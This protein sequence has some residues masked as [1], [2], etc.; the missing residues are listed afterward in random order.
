VRSIAVVLFLAG[1]AVAAADDAAKI[2]RLAAEP[3]DAAST[4][5]AAFLSS[6][7]AEVR[8][9]A[10]EALGG[11]TDKAAIKA[12]RGALRSFAK[13]ADLLPTVVVAVGASRDTGSAKAVADLAKKAVGSDLR[14]AR[15]CIDSLGQ[16]P[17]NAA[18]ECL[19]N[20]LAPAIDKRGASHPEL[21]EELHQSL[22]EVT[23][24]PFR[25]P[26]TF[27]AWWR[28]AKGRFEGGGHDIPPEG[29]RYRHDGWRFAI[30]RPDA[31]RFAFRKVQGAVVRIV[32]AGPKEEAGFAW[33]DVMAQSAAEG[34]PKTAADDAKA[35]RKWMEE[36]LAKPRDT[37]FGFRA[38]LGRAAAVGNEATGI[39]KE[40]HVVRW[41]TFS[42][43]K[44]GL[45]YTVSAH[46]ESGAEEA[47][48][49]EVDGILASFRLLDR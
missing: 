9:A 10:V 29:D 38:K 34:G 40:G 43:E 39:L 37:R 33:I 24:L 42:V 21:A 36:G 5:I 26:A 49:G 20:L 6:R 8:R 7:D 1:V 4:S 28:H 23:G 45:V 35:R 47:V 44:N 32:W 31:K 19:V 15:A 13:D 14:L 11:R 2:R 17:A 18:V 41:R 3:G 25:K 30:E 22:K 12:L 27:V 48:V 46:V 16:L